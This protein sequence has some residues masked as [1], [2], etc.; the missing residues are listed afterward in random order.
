[1]PCGEILQLSNRLTPCPTSSAAR[2]WT[3]SGRSG[4]QGRTRRTRLGNLGVQAILLRVQVQAVPECPL[5]LGIPLCS[6]SGRSGR[7]GMVDR[8]LH[9]DFAH[10]SSFVCSVALSTF[11]AFSSLGLPPAGRYISARPPALPC[12][13]PN[14]LLVQTSARPLHVSAFRLSGHIPSTTNYRGSD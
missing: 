1:M 11:S 3:P 14:R 8:S 5:P 7:P 2:D 10:L 9:L 4:L 13:I 6:D 12:H